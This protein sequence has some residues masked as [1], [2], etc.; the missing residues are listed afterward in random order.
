M[1]IKMDRR[2]YPERLEARMIGI[3]K[4]G[5]VYDGLLRFLCKSG[6]RGK[7]ASPAVNA[8]DGLSGP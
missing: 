3:D 1:T 5:A 4:A 2:V 8:E 6:F 7:P